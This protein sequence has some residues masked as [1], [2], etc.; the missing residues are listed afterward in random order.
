LGAAFARGP[1]IPEQDSN[2]GTIGAAQADMPRPRLRVLIPGRLLPYTGL[3]LWRKIC[4]EL[5]PFANV[6]LLD[7][8][9]FGQPF[10]DCA[11]VEVVRECDSREW[12]EKIAQWRPDCALLLSPHPE[13]SCYALAEM[14]ALAIAVVAVRT[15]ACSE[16]RID[17]GWNGFLVEPETDAVLDILR[18]FD[19]AR[20]RLATVV[21]ILRFS[22]VRTAFEMVADIRR[23]L[24]ELGEAENNRGTETLLAVLGKRL[25]GQEEILQ[26]SRKSCLR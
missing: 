24:P 11:G 14:Q 16:E 23:L 2:G 10:A 17:N 7:C 18:T 15:G 6:L 12:P 26:L 20:D 1:A 21:D 19:Q 5:R 8:G 9:D 25:R 3:G 22:P 4:N 13:G